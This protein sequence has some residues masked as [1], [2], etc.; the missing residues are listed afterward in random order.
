MNSWAGGSEISHLESKLKLAMKDA[1]LEVAWAVLQGRNAS[2]EL[3]VQV[4]C[5]YGVLL[6]HIINTHI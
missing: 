4:V 3:L 5:G 1:D 2:M 6:L